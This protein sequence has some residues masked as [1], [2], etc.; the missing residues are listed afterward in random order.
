M[1][2]IVSDSPPITVR[3]ATL[4]ELPQAAALFDGYRQFQGQASDIAACDRFLRE[5]MDHGEHVLFLAWQGEAA[6]GLAQLY[7][8]F[9][10]VSLRRVYVLNDLFVAAAGRRS[11][12][13]RALLAAIEH[14]A[15][16]MGASSLR[17]NVTRVNAP[18]QA[19]YDSAGWQRDDQF[20]MYQRFLQP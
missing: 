18:A 7:P 5:R 14:Y 20:F 6:I 10:S 9:S 4:A 1:N 16:A 2:P 17:L 13:G 8:I 12:A 19:L 3:Q 11:A 15:R